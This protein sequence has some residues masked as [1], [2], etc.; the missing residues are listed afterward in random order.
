MIKK[1]GRLIL[2]LAFAPL[3][4]SAQQK[5]SPILRAAISSCQFQV[6]RS[7]SDSLN[8]ILMAEPGMKVV[9]PG[10]LRYIGK[11]I[12][13]GKGTLNDIAMLATLNWVRY[14]DGQGVG[15]QK[16]DHYSNASTGVNILHRNPETIGTGLR[17]KG[18]GV[19][20][21]IVDVGFQPAH[22]N[23]L[24]STGTRN[25]VVRFWDQTKNGKIPPD[26][27]YGHEM[28]SPADFAIY[29]DFTEA[30]GTHVAGIMAGSGFGFDT[31][32]F[33]GVAPESDMVFV[34]IRFFNDTLPAGA[35]S[36]YL[37]ANPA[38]IDGFDYV[39]KYAHSQGKPAVCNLSWGMH[40]G[41]HDGTSLF[42]LA[43]DALTGPGKIIVGAAGNSNGIE[44]H[45]GPSFLNNNT[46][47]LRTLIVERRPRTEPN[48]E[49]YVDLWGSRNSAFSVALE[50][51]DSMGNKLAQSPLLHTKGSGI[52]RGFIVFGGDS[53]KYT[54]I[55]D[56]QYVNNQKPNMLLMI[57]NTQPA[58]RL[59]GLAVVSDSTIIHGWNSGGIFRYT[60]GRFLSSPPNHNPWPGFTMGNNNYTV[61][62][63]GGTAKSIITVGAH[64]AMTEYVDHWGNTHTNPFPAGEIADFSSLGPRVD[65]RIAPDVTAPGV[66]VISSYNWWANADS[67]KTDA[68]WWTIYKNDTFVY[69]MSNGTSMA[70]PQVAG[71]VAIMLSVKP[72]LTPE[73]ARTILQQTATA[74]D[75]TGVV[76]NNIFGYGR[77]NAPE[78]LRRTSVLASMPDLNKSS[79]AYT[80]VYPN[81][82][83]ENI[84]LE[85]MNSEHIEEIAIFDSRGRLLLKKPFEGER[86]IHE[87]L[88]FLAPGTYI[89]KVSG[90]SFTETHFI[91][92]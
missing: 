91:V 20:S 49:I 73:Q 61:G 25:R 79:N 24:D 74:D 6:V 10:K 84:T 78:A 64:S 92:K 69:K 2:L 70:A 4:L 44:M 7:C 76:P 52:N 17:L 67:P 40:T 21:G 5:V 75:K 83:H 80:R 15:L 88:D 65:G 18:A 22:I 36:D 26:F 38:I 60:S 87:N 77:V 33:T 72:D 55:A 48:E 51:Y 53:I 9:N 46:D 82:V 30:H 66:N 3:S 35:L 81:P 90:K 11:D 34:N 89:I 28:S 29:R 12:Y 39:F 32:R 37:I 59:V 63:N 27:G 58:N 31:G 56:D 43:L 1:I 85:C 16:A 50:M 57:T 45:M 41:P 13:T 23:F 14:I 68:G 71:I 8:F 19:I 47:T 54:I 42:D 62:E 86:I